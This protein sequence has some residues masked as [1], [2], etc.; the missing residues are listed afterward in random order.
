VADVP[1]GEST[2]TAW[3]FTLLGELRVTHASR[4]LPLPPP[5]ACSLLAELLLRPGPQRRERVVHLLFPDAPPGVGRRRLSDRLWVVRDALPGLPLQAS[6]EWLG[7]PREQ[8]WLDVEAFRELAAGT[9]LADW[10]AALGLYRDDLLPGCFDDWLLIERETL[11][12]E[13]VRLLYRASERLFRLHRYQEALP[14]LQRLMRDEPLDERALRLLM[15]G[16]AAL[17]Q[18]GAALAAFERFV[19]SAADELGMEPAPTTQALA[20]SIRRST[21][22]PPSTLTLPDEASPEPLRRRARDALNRGNRSVAERCID[23]LRTCPTA[24]DLDVCLLEADLALLCEEH[25]RGERILQGCGNDQ[26][27]VLARRAGVA[28][29]RR[30]CA[31]ALDAASQALLIAHQQE[32][33]D[34]SLEALLVLSRAQ[35]RLGQMAQ[36]MASAE[37][38]LDL[39]RSL[40]DPAGVVRALLI[41]GTTGFRQG[42]YRESM[43]ISRRAASLAREHGLRRYLAEALLDLAQARSGLGMLVDALPEIEEALSIWRDLGLRRPEAKAL[44]SLAT[45]YDLLGRH[46]EGLRAVEQAMEI[47][48]ALQDPFGVAKCQYHLAAGLPYRDEALLDEAMQLAEEAVTTFQAYDEL[49]WEASALATLGFLL[50]LDEEYA[51]ALGP[52]R[53]A[54]AKH[55]QLGE[56]AYLPDPLAHRGLA[57]LGLGEL[58]PALDCTRRAVL[59]LAHGALEGDVA[60]EIYYAHAV[61]LEAHGLDEQAETYLVRAYE[62]L[63]RYAEQLEDETARRAFFARGPLVRRLMEEVYARG[64]APNPDAGVVTRWLPPGRGSSRVGDGVVPVAWTLDAGPAD[65]ALKR[66]KGAIALRRSRLARMLREAASQGAR[67]TVRH[68]ANALKVSPRTIKRDMAA[69][70]DAGRI[71]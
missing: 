28:L 12:L 15:R 39:A 38:A 35:R 56:A 69:L 7:I 61:V 59:A 25:E 11:R 17:G 32:D 58:A 46:G 36:A 34:N 8:R 66:S 43:P 22:S 3:R 21:P 41:Q 18:R 10:Q 44:Q 24:A 5:R 30:D 1:D 62:N 9:T 45:V 55:D 27:A 70:R 33:R 64:I 49:G 13:H 29:T 71:S 26:A 2:R 4:T 57:L 65:V 19:A 60:S 47:Y 37:R 68:L 6:A 31:A 53:E 42:R 50:V 52:L 63:L 54:Y 51:A 20:Q 48:E 23:A 40:G 67:P 14:L 16:H